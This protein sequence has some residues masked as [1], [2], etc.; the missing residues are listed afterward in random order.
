MLTLQKKSRLYKNFFKLV[1]L[2]III[3]VP[4]F[5]VC[6]QTNFDFFNSIGVSQ[7]FTSYVSYK[8]S[9]MTRVFALFVSLIPTLAVLNIIDLLIRLFSHYENLEIFSS[10]V[11]Y[12]YRNLGNALVYWFIAK[13]IYGPLIT[14]TL[15]YNNPPGERFI[16]VSIDT[17]DVL[18]LITGAIVIAIASVMQ[19]AKE[20]SEE[21]DLT[22]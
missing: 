2:I 19:K 22:I 10:K 18:A 11:V 14:L 4:L 6:V 13:L 20:I 7:S 9:L 15:S 21:N 3:L 16:G 1:F 5:W 8:L 17:L 12:I